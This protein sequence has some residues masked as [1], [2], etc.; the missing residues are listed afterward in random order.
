M[1]SKELTKLR[2][3]KCEQG[4]LTLQVDIYIE[5]FIPVEV[6]LCNLKRLNKPIL[7]FGE[8]AEKTIGIGYTFQC[9]T[10]KCSFERFF[11]DEEEVNEYV[12]D[13]YGVD[14]KSEETFTETDQKFVALIRREGVEHNERT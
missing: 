9:S 6:L 3:P 4:L 14:A 10:L 12:R 11:D 13:L 5:R 8:A 1:S 7:K 2:C